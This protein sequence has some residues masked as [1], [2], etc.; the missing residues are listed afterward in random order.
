MAM[1]CNASD[2]TTRMGGGQFTM[3]RRREICHQ[4]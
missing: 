1:S 3:V 2:G 4:V